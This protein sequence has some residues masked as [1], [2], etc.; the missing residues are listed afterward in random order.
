LKICKNIKETYPD[1]TVVMLLNNNV[2][3]DYF[4]KRQSKYGFD[5]LFIWN[6]KSR[7]FFAMIKWLEDKKNTINDTKLASVRVILIVEDSPDFYSS[8]LTHLYRT[9]FKQTNQIVN[10]VRSDDLYKVL[11]LR[12]RPKVLLA[13]NYEEAME[14]FEEH[15]EFIFCLVTDVE[16]KKDGRMTKNAGIQLVKA[17]HEIK[18]NLPTILVSSERKN[19]FIA[20]KLDITFVNKNEQ[21]LYD[22]LIFR[23]TQKIGFGSFYFRNEQ[24][25]IL[26]KA[27]NISQFEEKILQV[28]SESILF[29]AKRNHFSKWLMARAEIQSANFLIEKKVDDFKDVD[30]VRA[31][32]LKGIKEYRDERPVGKIIPFSA[33]AC[34]S[35]ENIVKLSEGAFG[36][37]GRG[38]AFLNAFKQNIG[39]DIKFEGLKIKMPRTA[40]IG[41]TEF[42]E[43][44]L[45]HN[46]KQYHDHQMSYESLKELFMGFKLSVVLRRRLRVLL[47]S[48]TNPL[49][50]RSSGLFEDSISQPFAGIF[51]SYMIPNNHIEKSV[52]LKQ[53][54]NAIKLVFASVFSDT[55]RN[56]TKS[57][58]QKLGEEKMAVVI[59]ELIG[60]EN[61]NLFYPEISG[62]AQSYNFY[63]FAKMKP[64]DGFAIMAVGLGQ[65]V[66]EGEI[67]HRFCPK[68]PNLQFLSFKDQIKYTQTDFY[69]VDMS[70][71]DIDWKKGGMA[72]IKKIDI[73]DAKTNPN[74]KYCVSEFDYNNNNIYPG[75]SN[76]G[77]IVVNFASILKNKFI[78]LPETI[79]RILDHLIHAFD[80]PVEIE[81]VVDLNRDEDGDAAFYLLQVKPMLTPSESFRF[82]MEKVD[83]KKVILFADKSMGNGMIKDIYDIIYVR[84]DNFDKLKTEECVLELEKLNDKMGAE[85]KK[86]L[87]IGPGRWGTQDKFL[88]IPVRW[89]HISNA[90]VIVETDLEGFPLDASYGSHFFHNLTNL[91]IAYFSVYHSQE[92]SFINYELMNEANIMEETY[93]FRHVRFDHPLTIKIDGKKRKA[94]VSKASTS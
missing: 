23:I 16:Y 14:L 83:M 20:D 27:K 40:V 78:P 31:Y 82:D 17:L 54:C 7:I 26:D 74:L 79:E 33:A 21:D 38:L 53:L 50:V 63:P 24:Y 89:P 55:A 64:K 30:S 52:R 59:Q 43:F 4:T 36:G 25:E 2:Y 51:E 71:K 56:Y 42:E 37:K 85:K 11:K 22:N 84:T 65:H 1:L 60:N 34:K 9:I 3:I 58:D 90:K 5:K 45:N 46:L 44:Y 29:H 81:F 47:D 76:A 15:K 86:Y 73:Y 41:A 18:N 49:A 88:G 39:F 62:V 80:T 57:M 28:P 68:Y 19:Q 32:V 6:G 8:Y 70:L 77:P 67:S 66:V 48:Y 12:T 94:Y 87:L 69:A 10:E 13:S 75:I 72:T 92:N 91:N 93:Y 61:Q 35:D